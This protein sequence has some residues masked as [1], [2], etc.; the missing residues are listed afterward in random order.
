MTQGSKRTYEDRR[1]EEKRQEE[2]EEDLQRE[3]RKLQEAHQHTQQIMQQLNAIDQP[4]VSKD[5]EL[6]VRL[7]AS[8]AYQKHLLKFLFDF[9]PRTNNP[10]DP[11]N[12][13]EHNQEQR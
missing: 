2:R 5:T 1:K 12:I 10:Y 13:E 4:N 11:R 9:S 8:I 3:W 6:F 7:N